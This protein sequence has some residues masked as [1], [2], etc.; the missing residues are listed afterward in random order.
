M[1]RN[2]SL[3]PKTATSAAT[4]LMG[5]VSLLAVGAC[6]S[7]SGTAASTSS[8]SVTSPAN[9]DPGPLV[10]PNFREGAILDYASDARGAKDDAEAEASARK[11]IGAGAG[12]DSDQKIAKGISKAV[13]KDEGKD[14]KLITFVDDTGV[15]TGTVQ[16]RKSND[17][18]FIEVV[19]SCSN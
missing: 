4:L 9:V 5:V 8:G 16:F 2:V 11:F 7:V 17:E 10:C 12:S 18:W 15:P 1:Y 3:R 6:G 14:N 13:H 19:V